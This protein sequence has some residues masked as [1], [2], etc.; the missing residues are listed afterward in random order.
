MQL[1]PLFI[2]RPESLT[3]PED[4]CLTEAMNKK[5]SPKTVLAAGPS[6]K[7]GDLIELAVTALDEDG[8]GI[9]THDGTNVHVIGALPDERVRARLTHVGKRHL[10]AEAVEVLTPSRARLAQPSCK[11]AGSC[12]GCPLIVM[13]YPDQLNW[14]R[15]F[16]ERQI[17][18]YQ[19]LGAA[20]VLATLPSPN[21]LHY[22][23]SAKLVVSGTFRRPVIGIYRRNSHQVMDIGTCPL[24]HPLINRVV[25]AV[26]EGIAKCKVQVYNPRTGSGLLRYL[27]VRISERTGT[28]MA[29]FV[30][31]E[32]NYNEIHHLAKHL[33]Q[34]VPQ[35]EVVVQNVNSSE[36]NVILGQRDYFLTRQHALTEELGGIRF[37]ISPR[38]FFQV[39]SGGARIIYETVRQWSSLTGKESVVDLYCGIGGI[40]LFLAGTAREVHGIEVVEAAVNDAESNARLNRIHNCSF[41][42]GDAAELIEELVEEGER[43]DLVVLN[44]PRKGCDAGVLNKVAAA[45]P[46]RIV[47]VSCAPATLARDL[48]ILAGLGYATLRVQPVDMFPQ[49]PHVEN[50]ALLVKKLPRNDRLESPAKERSRPRASHKAKGGAV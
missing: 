30:T 24:H 35:V 38:S 23:N 36:G 29:V 7:R 4:S 37:T 1:K 44:P 40:A 11:R 33:Q 3:I 22:R 28:A 50:I 41:E 15:T 39:N 43:L 46:A 26:K 21:Q 45:G 47:Y 31:V 12:D 2:H 13:H 19:T 14:K 10:H 18:R 49:T 17:R 20:E 16:T 6:S 5:R 8:N 32:R 48:D 25:T 27:V 42:A 9:G 34:S